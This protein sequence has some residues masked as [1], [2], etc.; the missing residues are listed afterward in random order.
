MG[1]PVGGSIRAF[2]VG[3]RRFSVASD[4]DAT[5]DL[6]GFTNENQPNGDD[7]ARKI[8]TRK[9]WKVGNLMASI[10]DSIQD[11]EALQAIADDPTYQPCTLE[12]A[13]GVIYEGTG[14]IEDDLERSTQSATASV[15]LGG[16][17]RM[18]QQ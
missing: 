16:P 14:T 10:D 18:V 13:S 12:M 9:T 17:G 15:T 11:H 1:T 7:T 6:G 8:M 3:G 4:A 2:T 5:V